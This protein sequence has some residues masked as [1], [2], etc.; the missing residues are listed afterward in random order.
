MHALR[1]DK[2]ANDKRELHIKFI[3]EFPTQRVL[4]N[5]KGLLDSTAGNQKKKKTT[6]T[7]MHYV[8]KNTALNLSDE[9]VV[10]RRQHSEIPFNL[11]GFFMI[12]FHCLL[13][14]QI[15]LKL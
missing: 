5:V 2:N 14:F 8:I 6:T 10:L 7:T 3:F 12:L 15:K 4:V 9:V 13:I 1:A 11:K